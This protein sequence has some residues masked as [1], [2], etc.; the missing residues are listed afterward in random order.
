MNSGELVRES[1]ER[2][3]R[4]LR[5]EAEA[6]SAAYEFDFSKG[7]PLVSKDDRK[8]RYQWFQVVL[9]ENGGSLGLRLGRNSNA[10]EMGRDNPKMDVIFTRTAKDSTVSLKAGS[11]A[12]ALFPSRVRQAREETNRNAEERAGTTYRERLLRSLRGR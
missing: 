8:A 10:A 4:E 11:D 1:M 7:C 3:D 9:P 12:E 5:A 6:K 2:V